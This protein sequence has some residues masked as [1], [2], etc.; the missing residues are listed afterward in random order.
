MNLR[1]Y[2]DGTVGNRLEHLLAASLAAYDS[3]Q[4]DLSLIY[5]VSVFD[6]LVQDGGM[7]D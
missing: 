1:S 2:F 7:L 4:R 3:G 6:G 5:L